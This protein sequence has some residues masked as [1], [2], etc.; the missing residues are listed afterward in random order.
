MIAD[1]TSVRLNP[2]FITTDV[3]QF[4]LAL[5]AAAQAGSSEECVRWLARAID[6][7]RGELLPGYFDAWV[8]RERGWLAER[9]FQA[10]D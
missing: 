7:H 3:A 4:E 9:F 10:L 1:R 2:E 8:L 5:Q 6:L